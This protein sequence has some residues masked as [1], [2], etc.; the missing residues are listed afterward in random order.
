M[1][2]NERNYNIGAKEKGNR[3][4]TLVA[5]DSR[6]SQ[7]EKCKSFSPRVSRALPVAR[8]PPHEANEGIEA[9]ERCRHFA[10]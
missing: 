9:A 5:G 10:S 6:F 1:G 7:Y 2:M 8:R 3:E 4:A